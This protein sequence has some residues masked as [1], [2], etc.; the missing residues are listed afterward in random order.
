MKAVDVSYRI[1]WD[2]RYDDF[3]VVPIGGVVGHLEGLEAFS[4]PALL[5]RGISQ[6]REVGE[7]KGDSL[8]SIR[9]THGGAVEVREGLV[10]LSLT[11]KSPGGGER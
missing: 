6:G 7:E 2:A 8:G 10:S 9:V 1:P 4:C 5:V 3:S 11:W